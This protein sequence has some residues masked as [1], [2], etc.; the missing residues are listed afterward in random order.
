MIDRKSLALLLGTVGA[1]LALAEAGLRWF[2][3]SGSSRPETI[4]I[5]APQPVSANDGMRY[6]AK[7][8]AEPGTD[9]QWFL[10]NPP[11]LTTR[12]LVPLEMT[13]RYAD[14][15]KRSLYGP[16]AQYVWN[17]QFVLENTCKGGTGFFTNYPETVLA[18]DPPSGNSHPRF[19]F[20]PNAT[21]PSG[22]VTNQFGLRG[23]TV[24]LSKPPRTIR[25]AFVGASTT[26]NP[27][28]FPYSYPEYVVQWLNRFAEANRYNVHFEV[29][30]AGREGIASQDIAAI[31]KEELAPLH[32]DLVVYY[33]GANQFSAGSMI[34]P[35]P[36]PVR[37]IDAT[38]EAHTVP[39][40]MRTHSA[41]GRLVDRAL[42]NRVT[43]LGE[44]SKP[45]YVLVWPK[46]V[47]E[48]STD[49]DNPNLPSSLPVIVKDLDSIR[50]ALEPV[51]GRL[52][53]SSYVW[54]AKDGMRLAPIAHKNIY[55]QLHN[56]LW[57]LKY[58]DVRRLA[59][60]QNRIF[61]AYAQTRGITFLDVAER[62]PDDPDLYIDAIHMTELGER[63]KAWVAFQELIPFL[64]AEIDAGRLP[65]SSTSGSLSPP[66]LEATELRIHCGPDPGATQL[67]VPGA[68]RLDAITLAYDKASIERGKPVKVITAEGQGAFAASIP[69]VM[70]RTVKSA[71]YVQVRC[72]VLKGQIGFGILDRKTGSFQKETMADPTPRMADVY[73]A[74]TDPERADD[75][76][77]RN[78]AG[79]VRSQV[80]IED[81]AV[82]SSTQK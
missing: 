77:I 59:D 10:E 8:P 62:M 26:V 18:F 20:P 6:I 21:L 75:L 61:Q 39:R 57:P 11:P 32:P 80:L 71:Y 24:E 64:R 4:Q 53:L 31:V 81:V 12:K 40:W 46:G 60:F 33:E 22:L 27:H 30:N 13:Q 34:F 3:P 63:V 25:I 58:A 76:V 68:V 54:L 52:I 15:V 49:V 43:T 82:L 37:K 56:V 28:N 7:L 69:I 1:M 78:T 50:A 48:R 73:I 42:M 5:G 66:P 23:P 55:E 41:I 17:R 67:R 47:D 16:Q 72:R 19:R 70:D 29:L 74:M 36:P 2:T 35:P 14:F 9:R 38:E 45:A 44:P 65:Q 79:G 51:H